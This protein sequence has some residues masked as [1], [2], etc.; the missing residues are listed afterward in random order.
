MKLAA[1]LCCAGVVSD[2][3]VVGRYT[4]IIAKGEKDIVRGRE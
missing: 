4:K 3:E 2:A 1:A